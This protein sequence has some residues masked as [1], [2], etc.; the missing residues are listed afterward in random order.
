[1]I[2]MS[3]ALSS[4]EISRASS[5]VLVQTILAAIT[6]SGERTPALVVELELKLF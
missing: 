6:N 3:M 5:R 4:L 2:F 1:L